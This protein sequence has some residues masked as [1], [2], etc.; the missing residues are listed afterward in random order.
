M[1]KLVRYQ[2]ACLYADHAAWFVRYR[3]PVRQENGSIKLKQRTKML[4]RVADYPRESDIMPLKIE[5]MQR[6]NAVNLR[7]RVCGPGYKFSANLHPRLAKRLI[8]RPCALARVQKSLST[9]QL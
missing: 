4:G 1:T 3:V 6:L 7:R 8:G 5:F 9:S 2:D